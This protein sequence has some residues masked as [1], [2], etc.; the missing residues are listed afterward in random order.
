VLTAGFLPLLTLI[1]PR[2]WSYF[3]ITLI[4]AAALAFSFFNFD[5][6]R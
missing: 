2:C 6:R 3:L 4:M 1:K 5:P